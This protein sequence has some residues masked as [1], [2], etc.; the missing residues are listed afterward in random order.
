MSVSEVG[1]G[2]HGVVTGPSCWTHWNRSTVLVTVALSITPGTPAGSG[3]G[4]RDGDWPS[5]RRQ[6][7]QSA[8]TMPPDWTGAPP[9]MAVAET[10]V[11]PAG[12][13]SVSVTP[14]ARWGRGW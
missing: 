7:A 10:K 14:W 5:R 13:M 12:R 1:R 9:W 2:V 8:V 4:Q 11:I 3:P 6:A